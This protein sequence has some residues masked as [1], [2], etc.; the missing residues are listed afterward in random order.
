[1]AL[2]ADVAEA[3]VNLGGDAQNGSQWLVA[4]YEKRR[5]KVRERREIRRCGAVGDASMS[6]NERQ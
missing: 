5:K 3:A 4:D 2:G 6:V 1:M